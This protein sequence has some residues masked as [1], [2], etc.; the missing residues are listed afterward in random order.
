MGVVDHMVERYHDELLKCETFV[1]VLKTAFRSLFIEIRKLAAPV[2]M[3]VRSDAI[4][5]TTTTAGD[6]FYIVAQN[7]V[8]RGDMVIFSRR[9][10]ALTVNGELTDGR[11]D[12]STNVWHLWN[13]KQLTHQFVLVKELADGSLETCWA[14]TPENAVAC[15]EDASVAF[16]FTD[17]SSALAYSPSEQGTDELLIAAAMEPVITAD[18]ETISLAAAQAESVDAAEMAVQKTEDELLATQMAAE[19]QEQKEAAELAAQQ[20]EADAIRAAELA[21]AEEAAKKAAA[22]KEAAEIEAARVA[23]LEEA[24]AIDAAKKAAAELAAAQAAA[25]KEAER[26]AAEKLAAE[27]AALAKA[28]AEQ[29]AAEEAA[30][31][32]AAEKEAAELAA[33]KAAEEEAL[34]AAKAAEEREAAELAAAKAKAEAEAAAKA[35]A[36]KEAAEKLAAAAEAE[37]VA[38]QLAAEKAEADR[39]AAEQAEAE[40]LAEQAEVERL[41][42]EKAEI[43]RLAAEQAEADRIAAEEAERLAAEQAEAERLATELVETEAYVDPSTVECDAPLEEFKSAILEIINNSRANYQVCGTET[44]QPVQPLQWLDSL[45]QAATVHSNDMA[46]YDFLSHTGTNGMQPLDRALE[47]GFI[48][49][50]VG[51]NV[52]YGPSTVTRAHSGFMNSSGHCRNI[53]RHYFTHVGAACRVDVDTTEQ[54]SVRVTRY[55]TVVFGL[56]TQ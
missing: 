40:R 35:A 30:A 4:V 44:M 24:A 42:A 8:Y 39:L 51:E 31:Q 7:N 32:A 14:E 38:A 48:G 29:K 50:S 12:T 43:D 18:R 20:A 49:Y 55:W 28:A 2:M 34:A 27:E 22:E 45:Q 56:P 1:M 21:K 23:A 3:Q 33:R 19:A 52:A 53:M 15:N 16:L 13:R 36:E 46:E 41:A 9:H 26:L 37:R 47:A 6:E 10:F 25:E 54:N 5:A 11:Y 17:E